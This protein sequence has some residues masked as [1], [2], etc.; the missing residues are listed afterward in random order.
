L[1]FVKKQKL[2][3]KEGSSNCLITHSSKASFI[4]LLIQGVP[5]EKVDYTSG[6]TLYKEAIGN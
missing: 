6:K 1:N 4:D 3:E 2:Y 5:F